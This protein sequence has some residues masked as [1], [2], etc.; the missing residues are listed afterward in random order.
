MR[1]AVF[2]ATA[3]GIQLA[4]KLRQRLGGTVDIFVKEG[5]PADIDVR[6]YEKLGDAVRQAFSQYEA[7]IFFMATGIVVRLI[8]P[9]L[10]SKLT[11]PAV[12]VLDEQALHAISLL[13]GHVGGANALTSKIASILDS[14]PVIT[15][16]T[17]VNAR[18]APDALAAKL[19]LRPYPKPQIQVVNS[20][21]LDGK[22]IDWLIDSQLPRA[23]FFL[24]A[25]SAEGLA[26]SLFNTRELTQ[27]TGLTVLVTAQALPVQPNFLYLQ[28]RRLIAGIGCRRGTPMGL[29]REALTSACSQIGQDISAV[30]MLA[31]SIVKQN[32]AGL[33]QLGETLGIDVRFFDNAALQEKINAYGLDESAFVKNE[34]GV[35]NVCS[36]A[37]LCCVP[38][39]RFA[40]EK[41]KFTKVTVALVCE[42]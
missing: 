1:C 10:K 4:A 16:A 35:G 39:G 22:K 25:L 37:A 20:G 33:L 13:S 26:P 3:H 6:R 32:E 28:P 17:D 19:G 9:C 7:L 36:A 31:S 38:H 30:S 24:R 5:R 41:T 42:K 27:H 15:T 11:D 23:M 14:D 2:T 40:L 8:A 18:I 12:I 21:L 29:I 34:I